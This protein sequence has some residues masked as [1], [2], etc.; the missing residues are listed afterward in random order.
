MSYEEQVRMFKSKVP[1]GIKEVPELVELLRT[2][3]DLVEIA[4]EDMPKSL[5]ESSGYNATHCILND[6]LHLKPEELSFVV[7]RVVDNAK[8]KEYL[9]KEHH[10]DYFV[11]V[12]FEHRTGY[13]WSNSTR[14]F[15]EM[16]LAR[17][18]SQQ[19]YDSEG[20]QF[21]SIIA[22]LAIAYCEEHGIPD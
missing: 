16:E 7:Y 19:E 13:M 11:F 8:S 22:H 4:P 5:I 20:W 21:R 3:V 18:V 6:E 15:L 1:I 9:A 17:G 2:K 14:I 12:I 10:E